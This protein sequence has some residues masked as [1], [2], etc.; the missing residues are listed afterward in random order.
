MRSF[1]LVLNT[2]L[3]VLICGCE[4][5]VD[6][7][8]LASH[9]SHHPAD[10]RPDTGERFKTLMEELRSLGVREG[11]PDLAP[12]VVPYTPI[13]GLPRYSIYG[14]SACPFNR[15]QR[16]RVA[17]HCEDAC[18]HKPCYVID[19]DVQRPQQHQG[20]IR[21][22][23]P[24]VNP[25]VAPLVSAMV[26]FQVDQTRKLRVEQQDQRLVSPLLVRTGWHRHVA[27][28][29]PSVLIAASRYPDKD[30]FPAL[31]KLVIDYFDRATN[32]ISYT[33][34]LVLRMLNTP[35]PQR[36]C[37]VF[38]SPSL[39]SRVLTPPI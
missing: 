19:C 33:D 31:V 7:G 20:Y 27:G 17:R 28:H 26:Q 15:I 3:M 14:C 4:H 9:F 30:E 36:T 10:K 5:V 1:S 34:T 16:H 21:I 11:L 35:E 2:K 25:A 18:E 12:S 8:K 29:D 32:L 22:I 13:A 39:F 23:K 6:M 24:P 38:F 37:V